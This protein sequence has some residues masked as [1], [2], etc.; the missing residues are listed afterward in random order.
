[1]KQRDAIRLMIVDDSALVRGILKSVFK[2]EPD[3][4][5]VAEAP[6][7][8]IACRLNRELEPDAVIMDINMPVMDGLQATRVMMTE[9]RVPIII[10]SS[11]VD[12]RVG[13]DAIHAGAIDILQKPD[14]DRIDSADFKRDIK[15]RIRAALDSKAAAVKTGSGPADRSAKSGKKPPATVDAIVIG[16]STGG[17]LA[18]RE[19]LSG[20]PLSLPVGIALVQHMEKGF[21]SGYATWL[22]E[23]TPL[24]VRL[25][26]GND[27]FRPG[28][29]IVAPVDVHLVV[30]NRRLV[31]DN[32]PRILNQK[33]AVDLLFQTAAD[34]YRERLL[35]VLLTGMG[36]DGADG[37]RQ[38]VEHDGYTLVQDRATSAIFGM[39][40]AAIEEGAA[41]EIVGL[42]DISKRILE[43]LQGSK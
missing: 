25:G 12:T 11:A 23:S 6:N 13:F 35:G 43:I 29:V 5:I 7:G 9:R 8:E 38:I 15:G 21:D 26:S 28:E 27:D 24:K 14:I 1:M 32:G 22:D 34:C 37:C 20:L 18:V 3:I 36:R 19:I 40:K 33:P 4:T 30:K 2:D 41:S 31:F 17:P 42:P 16:T 10:F 39:P